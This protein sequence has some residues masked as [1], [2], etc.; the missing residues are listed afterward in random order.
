MARPLVTPGKEVGRVEVWR[1]D[2][3]RP[4]RRRSGVR[5]PSAGTVPAYAA[6]SR[7]KE[8]SRSL[9]AKNSFTLPCLLANVRP[10]MQKRG[11]A[12]D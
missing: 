11:A 5:E 8:T 4:T 10:H 9:P 3:P 6:C 7:A 2:A 1:G 12:C